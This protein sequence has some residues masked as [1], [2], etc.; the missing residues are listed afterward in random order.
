[1][2]RH[3]T[4]NPT[5]RSIGLTVPAAVHGAFDL[6]GKVAT[7]KISGSNQI[8]SQNNQYNN[9]V[10][11]YNQVMS[12]KLGAYAQAGLPSYLAYGGG[13]GA[14]LPPTAQVQHGSS[15]YT[16]RILGNPQSVPITGTLAQSTAGFGNIL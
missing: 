6:A 1:M 7:G 4:F 12:Q 15:A 14:G 16:S 8:A 3:N 5:A 13:G 10:K 2:G 9:M 11:G